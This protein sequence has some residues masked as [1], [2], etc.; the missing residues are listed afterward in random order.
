M[1]ALKAAIVAGA[2][3]VYLGGS[4]HNARQFAKNFDDDSL[5]EAVELCKSLGVKVY[6]TLNTLL[7]DR[8]LSAIFP[9]VEM[10]CSLS[11]DA[12]I[13]QDLGLMRILKS[14]VPTLH[15]IAS[16][17]AAFN[18]EYS[19][20]IAK[21][22]GFSSLVAGREL[23]EKELARLVKKSPIPVEAFV[24]GALCYSVSGQCYMS[25]VLGR[26]SASRGRC[27]GPCRLPYSIAGGRS[28]HMLSLKDNYL[29]PR[30]RELL[31]T[32]VST[33][34]IEGRMKRPEYVSSATRLYRNIID[35]GRRPSK[36]ERENLEGI[37]SRSGFTSAYFDG[38]AN[39]DM[40]GMRDETVSP[41]HRVL[42]EREA[43]WLSEQEGASVRLKGIKF[44][45][46][47]KAGMPSTLV[48]VCADETVIVEGDIPEIAISR[49]TTAGDAAAALSKTGGSLFRCD[50]VT[51]DIEEGLMLPRSSLNEMRRRAVA[52]MEERVDTNK[53]IPCDGEMPNEVM[54]LKQSDTVLFGIFAH[55]G[56]VPQGAKLD[57]VF[58]PFDVI[59]N[60]TQEVMALGYDIG[61]DLPHVGTQD[62]AALAKA[63]VKAAIIHNLG[64]LES[65]QSAGLMPYGGAELNAFNSGTLDTL[66]TL[67]LKGATIS[68][69]LSFAQQRD[70]IRPLDCG[71]IA[72]GRLPLMTSGSCL[73]KNE[74][75]C[76]GRCRLP[77]ELTDR[78]GEQFVVMKDGDSCRNVIYNSHILY[79]ADKPEWKQNSFAMLLF[80][81]ETQE[82]ART[83]INA[84][85]GEGDAKPE[86]FT[87]GL[88]MRGVE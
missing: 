22:L 88:Y 33:L 5:K 2:D 17:Q 63:G 74:Y 38:E 43:K 36:K 7:T 9:Y 78:Q 16:T 56:Q 4:I 35:E 81:D 45:L 60:R 46:T 69:E 19:A 29:A 68:F 8:E 54:P 23:S 87:R 75:G 72:Y 13:V 82:V 55:M 18:D 76:S 12:L 34:K 26:R 65:V 85:N 84:Y 21:D 6:V 70:L 48:A 39:K 64:Q 42:L 86:K 28:R 40:F 24:H 10:L 47:L 50:G 44:M 14:R 83:V 77:A 27:A 80:T 79:L 15:V 30:I 25:S 58:L 1:E 51:A 32:G 41:S 53:P 66:R 37:F 59:E 3:A 73:I 49:P 31:K 62:L 52:Q 57:M 67:G 20:K 61:V 11:I 71:I